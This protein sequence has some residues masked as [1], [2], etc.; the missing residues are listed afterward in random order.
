MTTK[1]HRTFEALMVFA[2]ALSAV[3]IFVVVYDAV[4]PVPQETRFCRDADS[5]KLTPC[6][7]TGERSA[8]NFDRPNTAVGSQ[9]NNRG[10]AGVT[11]RRAP[12]AQSTS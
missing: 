11:P 1:K 5:L 7:F 12:A 9:L 6:R 8:I 3:G 4:Q 10:S 2:A